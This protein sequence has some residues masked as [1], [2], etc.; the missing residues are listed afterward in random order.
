MTTQGPAQNTADAK[1]ATPVLFVTA[2][3]AN[4]IRNLLEQRGLEGYVLRIGVEG[5]GCS[6]LR[7]RM[8]FDESRQP[9]DAVVEADGVRLVVDPGSLPYLV[10][11]TVDFADDLMGGGFRVENPNAQA[12]CGCGSSFKASGDSGGDASC[13]TCSH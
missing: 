3:A 1:E 2:T 4:T 11:A 7:Y 5:G 10:G 9:T 12:S 8:A 6:G 13:G